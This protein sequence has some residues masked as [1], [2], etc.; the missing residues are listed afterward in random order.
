MHRFGNLIFDLQLTA[1]KEEYQKALDKARDVYLQEVLPVLSDVMDELAPPDCW[2]ELERLEIDLGDVN[3]P[4]WEEAFK[5]RCIERFTE[6][7]RSQLVF[8]S[9]GSVAAAGPRVKTSS[10]WK[11]EMMVRYLE[12]GNYGNASASLPPP[13]VLLGE[14]LEQHP[15]E[16]L[17]ALRESTEWR[18]M[19]RRLAWYFPERLVDRLLEMMGA[20]YA[21]VK[22]LLILGEHLGNAFAKEAAAGIDL[23]W[24]LRVVLIGMVFELR[25]ATHGESV[26]W[27]GFVTRFLQEYHGDARKLPLELRFEQAISAERQKRLRELWQHLV[28]RARVLQAAPASAEANHAKEKPELDANWLR[29]KK[30]GTG[31]SIEVKYAGIVL[32]NPFLQQFFEYL[33]LVEQGL[34]RDEV[35]QFRAVYLLHFLATSQE[36]AEEGELQLLKLLCGLSTSDPIYLETP[37]TDDEKTASVE[38]LEAVIGYWT[39]MHGSSAEALQEAFLQRAGVLEQ[40]STGYRLRVE[41]MLLDVLLAKLPWGLSIVHYPWMDR[42]LYVEWG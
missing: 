20:E 22:S 31:D 38:L 11:P 39:P 14:L 27:D 3:A 28:Q 4:N 2:V 42:L 24:T 40:G 13:Q 29:S 17:K 35:A 19:A 12:Q 6:E 5:L 8:R 41:S 15:K 26:I 33:G 21:A 1:S 37:L 30:A 9:D 10:V 34:F 36:V 25:D 7:L 16:L 18:N 32:L 23:L